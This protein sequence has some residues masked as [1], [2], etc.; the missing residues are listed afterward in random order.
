MA[1]RW[2]TAGLIALN[3]NFNFNLNIKCWQCFNFRKW[4]NG[5]DISCA[6]DALQTD[7][8]F[9]MIVITHATLFDSVWFLIFMPIAAS[10]HHR[11]RLRSWKC[12]WKPDHFR[13]QK[14]L[15]FKNVSWAISLVTYATHKQIT[16]PYHVKLHFLIFTL[17]HLNNV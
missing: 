15:G 3:S 14:R 9:S 6:D 2:T 16:N 7:A 8:D 5:F 13:A 1:L 12:S 17:N 4:K 10:A 11:H